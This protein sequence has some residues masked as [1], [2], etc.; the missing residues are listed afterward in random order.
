[1]CR[2]ITEP[3]LRAAITPLST[4]PTHHHHPHAPPHH[5][6]QPSSHASR[7]APSPHHQGHYRRPDRDDQVH[8][9]PKFQ[10]HPPPPAPPPQLPTSQHHHPYPPP[11][12]GHA[13]PVP[14]AGSSQRVGHFAPTHSP[15]STPGHGDLPR[16]SHTLSASLHDD[17]VF[18]K[19][20]GI[21]NKLTPEKFE[22]L[23][24]DILN[25]G[26]DSTVILKGVILLIFEKALDEPKYSSMYA[27]LCKRLA[28]NAPN[29]D[30][31]EKPCTFRRLLLNKCKDEFENRSLIAQV[32]EK[33]F[34][35][36]VTVNS[37]SSN[38][39]TAD[40]EEAKY[41]AKRKMLGNIK[42]IGELG[43]L[44][45]VHDSI[46][47]RCCEQLLVGR[48]KQP[49]PDQA[50]DLECLCHLMK[51]CGKLLDTAK[52]KVRMDQYFDRLQQVTEN[53]QMPTRIRFMVKDILE[54]RLC[55]WM[56][57]R[58]GKTPEGPR[59]IQQVR[60]DAYRDGCIY[61]PQ[62]NSP[63]TKP[64]T[65]MGGGMGS[66]INPLEGSF[67]DGKPKG[68]GDLFG[69]GSARM[70]GLMAPGNSFLGTGPGT[71]HNEGYDEVTLDGSPT[72]QNR[73][74]NGY[75]KK[76][77][78]MRGSPDNRGPTPNANQ[79]K[80]YRQ[81]SGSSDN[82][83]NHNMADF[84]NFRKGG[85][86]RQ[87]PVH[88]ND[89][90]F[91][92]RDKL[93]D[94][95]DRYS[96]NRSKDRQRRD[97]D[98][99]EA[100]PFAEERSDNNR[101]GASEGGN[102]YPN[103]RDSYY[104]NNNNNS[105]NSNNRSDDFDN[106]RR[107]N[108]LNSSQRPLDNNGRGSFQNN[109]N[110]LNGPPAHRRG[111]DSNDFPPP[112]GS[113]RHS[114]NEEFPPA[115]TVSGPTSLPP[116]LKK[117]VLGQPMSNS[118]SQKDM[119]VSLRPQMP[120]SMIFK[121]KTPAML[122][123]SAMRGGSDGD[124]LMGSTLSNHSS[125]VM[126]SPN[127]PPIIKQASL[128]KGNRKDKNKGSKGPT[129]EEV[130]AKMETILD[131]LMQHQSTNE[132]S[133]RW[134]EHQWLPTK[135]NQTAV[136]HF[137]KLSLA[138]DE[139]SRNLACAFIQQLVRDGTING[140]HCIEGLNKILSQLSEIERSTPNAKTN[141]AD[142][143]QWFIKEKL[144]NLKEFSEIL[145]DRSADCYPIFMHTL[146][147]L[148]KSI[149][150]ETLKGLFDE[151]QPPIQ[152]AD[153]VPEEQRSD[154]HL[155][156]ILEECQLAFLMPLLI[157]QQDLSKQIQSDS[158]PNALAKWIQANV[159]K[160]IQSKGGFIRA[161]FQVVVQHIA[162]ATTLANGVNP[163]IQP[164]KPV[165]ESEKEL[166]GSFR[167]VLQPYVRDNPKLQLHAVYALQLFCHQLGFPKGMLLR[168]FVNFYELDIMDEHAFLQWKEDVNE[169]YSGKGKA[170]FQVNQWLTWLEE[171]ESEEEEDEDNE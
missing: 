85:A 149:G 53:E 109:R 101:G 5:Q 84:S 77:Q 129:R 122:P 93:P 148:V 50:E 59:T 94:F 4:P 30:P 41:S 141:L 150:P 80:R 158:D 115:T 75:D 22:K 128:E 86:D 121:P 100:H 23:T 62:A 27:Q 90:F 15:P 92:N 120:A 78:G 7:W 57:R 39:G 9:A 160:D 49:I 34:E 37:G 55:R 40:M 52:A 33:K 108:R 36:V 118:G 51:T 16:L 106:N 170:L 112:G 133:E 32:N 60:E 54:L 114:F 161:L 97:R 139:A 127:E 88:S 56:T 47:H 79:P 155:V 140:T 162:H 96:A 165:A 19:V 76:D 157:I 166:L 113:G 18:R 171:A 74:T 63:P 104:T 105:N 152:L 151:T 107:N 144:M 13:G 12:A 67:F 102:R 14:P 61:M 72:P 29:F 143:S 68:G 147:R 103:D 130:F 64:M 156:S 71:I 159:D 43:K 31:P 6:P 26:L 169:T 45:I 99:G 82:S 11:Q 24:V 110:S 48:R 95:G 17:A 70:M 1:M 35:S 116:R 168:L 131:E 25:V 38:H 89:R 126:M 73:Q 138:K 66:F 137:L 28:E 10:H 132:A 142:V 58:V 65:P 8:F 154:E 111:F 136:T 123:K 125:M 164:D 124:S 42:F 167:P 145:E 146:K 163:T 91:N 81:N 87:A 83:S 117:M 20:R 98:N 44:Q 135:M 134:K 153:H 2:L 119:E 46:L 3:A 69:G 21:L